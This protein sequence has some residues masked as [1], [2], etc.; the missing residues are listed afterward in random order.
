MTDS[1]RE[2]PEPDGWLNESDIDGFIYT[3]REPGTG[4]KSREPLWSGETIR[5]EIEKADGLE[6]LEE[7]FSGDE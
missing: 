4:V 2:R 3:T 1:N 7:V 6:E 5:A